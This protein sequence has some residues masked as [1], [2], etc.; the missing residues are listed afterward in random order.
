[1]GPGVFS[2]RIGRSYAALGRA[3]QGLGRPD[4]ARVAFS[5]ALEHLVP[6]QGEQHPETR[7]VRRIASEAGAKP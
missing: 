7:E 6:S 3:L 5:K 4:E 2:N 1:V